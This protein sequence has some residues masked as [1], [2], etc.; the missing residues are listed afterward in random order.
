[1]DE[2]NDFRTLNG[3]RRKSAVSITESMEDYLEMICRYGQE[4]GYVR[5]QFLAEQLH[6]T[7]G[8]AS[9]MVS[10]LRREGYLEE[11][12]YG[13]VSPTQKGWQMGKEVLRRHN[14]L[15]RF[16]S[17][18]NGGGNQLEQVELVE[19]FILPDTL[20][21]LEKLCGSPEFFAFS[22]EEESK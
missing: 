14:I 3:Y 16:F 8:S 7:P 5:V 13:V 10:H 18:L 19:H 4:H 1:M 9:K 15:S 11:G 2:E 20:S 17:L 12:R 22:R 6:V 21:N